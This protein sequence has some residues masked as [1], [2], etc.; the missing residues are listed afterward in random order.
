MERAATLGWMAK[1]MTSP[2]PPVGAVIVDSVGRI[3]GEGFTQ[4]AGGAHA[5]VMAV[6]DAGDAACGATAVV[7][8]EPCAHTGR[9]GPCTSV[10]LEAGISTVVYAVADPHP[11]AA[12]GHE[13]LVDAGVNVVGGFHA[14]DVRRGALRAWLHRTVTGR[15]MV[16][17]KTAVTLDGRVA[18][19]DGTSQW[20]TSVEA[21]HHVHRDRAT[22]DALIVGTGTV[23]SD[24]PRLTARQPNGELYAKQPDHVVLG[25][26]V[27]PTTANIRAH[28][29]FQQIDSHRLPQVIEELTEQGYVDL[30]IE[31]G[32]TLASAAVDTDVVDCIQWYV[33]PTILGSG[34]PV[35]HIPRVSTLTDKRNFAIDRITQLGPDVLIEASRQAELV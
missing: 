8:L 35:V 18:A 29:R 9:T 17:I 21:R 19:P 34:E 23:L 11:V 2:N 14:D 6:R 16:T 25:S 24:N 3:V 32:P 26:R 22:R 30:L 33:A 13:V 28:S 20:I 31:G 27:V 12:G 7:T 1:G 5:E 4:P 15:A 10:L